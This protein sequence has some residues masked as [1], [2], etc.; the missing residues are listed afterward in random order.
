[1]YDIE[2]AAPDL[3]QFGKL[4]N[5][6]V[7]YFDSFFNGYS[8]FSERSLVAVFA[9]TKLKGKT[10]RDLVSTFTGTLKRGKPNYK[11]ARNDPHDYSEEME[12]SQ[13]EFYGYV[14][15]LIWRA[16]RLYDLRN[17]PTYDDKTSLWSLFVDKYV[18]LN[19]PDSLTMLFDSTTGALRFSSNRS[20]R[21]TV[22]W[23]WVVVFSTDQLRTCF[24]LKN[25][26]GVMS[27]DQGTCYDW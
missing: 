15:R 10:A 19:K 26:F 25:G 24:V 18:E 2:L 22:G 11:S 3:S 23:Q 17:A 27:H 1:M 16:Q 20:I 13:A 4:A 21:E 12:E 6:D 7:D 8:P 14:D 5:A 9:Y